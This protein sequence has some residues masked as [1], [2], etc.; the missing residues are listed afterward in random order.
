MAQITGAP[1][2]QLIPRQELNSLLSAGLSILSSIVSESSPTSSSLD[3]SA[4]S[5]TSSNGSPFQ[6]SKSS[7]SPSSS[8]SSSSSS[9]TGSSSSASSTSTSDPTSTS[10]LSSVTSATGSAASNQ[11]STNN[12]HHGGGS[13]KNLPIILGV[14]LGVLALC[15]LALLLLCCRRRRRKRGYI[16]REK[17]RPKSED[18]FSDS[19]LGVDPVLP[20]VPLH[21]QDY[22][23]T[24]NG[25]HRYPSVPPP[26]QLSNTRH[27]RGDSGYGDPFEDGSHSPYDRRSRRSSTL[28]PVTELPDGEAMAE[29]PPNGYRGRS[30]SSPSRRGSGFIPPGVPPRSPQR[31]SIPRK[32]VGGGTGNYPIDF[33]DYPPES[34]RSNRYYSD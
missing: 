18:G 2:L 21:D 6:T 16:F 31:R 22:S 14:V 33:A 30:W 32:P 34:T 20:I 25:H 19:D 8:S 4:P 7:S 29:V 13:N 1:E 15:L 23:P 3:S 5:S 10:N 11:A 28:D 9:G 12:S 26:Y 27:S 17:R 24:N